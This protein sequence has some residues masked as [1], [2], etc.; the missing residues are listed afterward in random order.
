MTFDDNQQAVEDD[1]PAAPELR[2]WTPYVC[3]VCQVNRSRAPR[4]ATMYLYATI[5]WE[6]DETQVWEDGIDLCDF[7]A[8]ELVG[9]ARRCRYF[10][11][12]PDDDVDA[13]L[14]FGK[15]GAEEGEPSDPDL[16]CSVCRSCGNQIA[17]LCG[18]DA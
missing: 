11:L 5:V 3:K 12:E 1:K 8:G 9:V 16:T 10:T 2:R 15:L 17:H 18:L 13:L 7:H 14:E 4:E 6:T